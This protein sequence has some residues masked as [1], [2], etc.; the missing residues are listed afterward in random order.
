MLNTY[1][2]FMKGHK[3]ITISDLEQYLEKDQKKDDF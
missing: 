2:T 1:K 3:K